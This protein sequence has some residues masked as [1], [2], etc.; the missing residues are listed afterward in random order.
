MVDDLLILHVTPQKE[1]IFVTAHAIIR[2]RWS[3]LASQAPV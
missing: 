1:M 3:K 2:S